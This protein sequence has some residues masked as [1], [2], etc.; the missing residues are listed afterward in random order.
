MKTLGIF[1]ITL[2][3][4]ASRAQ[5]L[6]FED[7]FDGNSVDESKWKFEQ[8]LTGGGDWQFQWFVKDP[9]NAFIRNGVLHLKPT[10]TESVIG[11]NQLSRKQVDIDAA[12]CTSSFNYGCSRKGTREHIINPIRSASIQTKK[13]FKYGIVEIRA[14]LPAGDWLRPSIKLQPKSNVYGEWPTSGE[15]DLVEARGNRNYQDDVG[16]IGVDQMTATMHFGPNPKA[17]G[18]DNAHYIKSSNKGFNEDFHIYKLDWSKNGI[19]IFVDNEEIGKFSVENDKSFWELG[20]FEN[21][22]DIKDKTNPWAQGTAMAPFDQEFFITIGLA[23][24]GV[25]DYFSDDFENEPYPKP[26]SNASPRAPASFWKA[27]SQWLSTWTSTE[28]SADFQIDYVKVF[29][30]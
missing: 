24:G 17:N 21:N 22:Q 28:D 10:M 13:S 11:A 25:S 19:V 29:S 2:F 20:Q 4:V 15:I 1:V 3:M 5:K 12:V 18:W 14:K 9:K 26:W 27:K 23:V 6:L 16:S 8:T 7:S 30:N